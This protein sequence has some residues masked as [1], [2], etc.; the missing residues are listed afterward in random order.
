MQQEVG[1]PYQ[2]GLKR[3]SEGFVLDFN[4]GGFVGAIYENIYK[5]FFNYSNLTFTHCRNGK[6]LFR[7]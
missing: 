3:I 5:T 1:K 4:Q 2:A 6:W 7:K